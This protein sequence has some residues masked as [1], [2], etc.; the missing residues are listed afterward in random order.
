MSEGQREDQKVLG[1]F[2]WRDLVTNDI[3]QAIRFY[4]SLFGWTIKEADMGPGGTY[5]MIRT[6]GTE[7]GGFM[8]LDPST[9]A[10]PHW[11]SY[12]TVDDVAAA[13]A[14]AEQRGGK[15]LV[16]PTDIP[17]VGT[18]SMIADPQG[19]VISPFKP[20]TWAG[21]GITQPWPA[22]TFCWQE[23]HAQDPEGEGKFHA[24]VFGWKV[25][26][27][28][29]GMGP[30][31]VFKRDNGVDGGGMLPKS[32]GQHVPSAWLPYIAVENTSESAAKITELGGKIWV[33]PTDIP[34]VGRFAVAT[35]PQGA[36][37]AILGPS[38]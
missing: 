9:G 18:F 37:F 12:C 31:Y 36:H 13:V 34:S 20:V 14:T 17:G 10:P 6:A 19:A 3:D 2:V 38:S 26:S 28:D 7:H 25:S 22:G 4:T 15:T 1:K 30:Y 8:A 24:E 33:E 16:P 21:E 5:K 29:A 23:L 11:V 27:M 35:D 32:G